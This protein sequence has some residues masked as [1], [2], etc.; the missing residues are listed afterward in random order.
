MHATRAFPMHLAVNRTVV[1]PSRLAY[2]WLSKLVRSKQGTLTW[3]RCGELMLV[4]MNVPA[5]CTCMS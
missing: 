1:P 3:D 2:E 5:E 4:T